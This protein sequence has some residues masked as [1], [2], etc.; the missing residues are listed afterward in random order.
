MFNTEEILKWV[1]ENAWYLGPWETEL[2]RSV[3]NGVWSYKSKNL[4]QGFVDAHVHICRAFTFAPEF[5]PHGLHLNEIAD[6]DLPAKQELTGLLHDGKAYTE[7][8]LLE[9]MERQILRAARIGTR[10]IWG[11]VDTTPDIGTR[12]F[13]IALALK[14]K[15]RDL[16]SLKIACYAL[17]GL[18][19]PSKDPERL[20]LMKKCAPLADFI[21]GL[22]EK[23]DAPDKIGFKGHVNELLELG[24]QNKKEVHLHVDQKNSAHERGSFMALEC[25]EGLTQ[26]KFKWFTSPDRPKLWLVHVISPSCY[27]PDKFSRLVSKLVKYN[28]GVICCPVAGISMR[29]LRSEQAPIHNS[30]ARVIEMLRAGVEVRYGTDN[31]NDFLVPSNRGLIPDEVS[32]FSNIT[33]NYISHVLALVSMGMSLSNGDR[34]LLKQCLEEAKKACQNH[35]VWA[36]K[37]QDTI[38][39]QIDY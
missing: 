25:L 39:F 30:L 6:L 36:E 3:V 34:A 9:R 15:H 33:R 27:K 20:E 12:A 29:Q 4:V 14:E 26:E 37:A 1:D 31:V 2:I 38:P 35:S 21:V 22:P 5:F 8:S 19:D 24:W 16:I 28:V 7:E 13:D 17:F 18:K 11:V 23:D 32:V 10:E